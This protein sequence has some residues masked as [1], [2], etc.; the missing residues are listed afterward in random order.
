VSGAGAF[1]EFSVRT[2]DI[3]ESL[4]FYKLLG[5]EELSIGEVWPHK[6][7][8]VSDGV[9]NIGLH[10][11]EFDSPAL[12][13]VQ[14]DLAK[15]ARSM[16]DHGFEFTR[17]QLG[18][19]AFNELHLSDLD[20]N[21]V[22]MLEARTHYGADEDHIDSACGTWFELTMPVKDAVHAAR[23][24]APLAPVVLKMRE[25]PTT[26]MRFDAGGIALGLSESIALHGPSLCFKCH[27][28][29]A[30]E[31][32]CEQHGFASQTFPGFEGAFRAIKA[33]EGTCLYLFDED[34]LGE[35]IEVDESDDLSEFPR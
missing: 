9:L 15:H 27:D 8:V 30:I 3:L 25:E 4:N 16:S 33:P 20:Q 7:T 21:T 11:R 31:A 23:F 2:P 17:M 29:D 34:F 26:H 13:F 14:P 6:Y 1:L 35:A 5:F 18:E 19:D 32:L 12:T 10:D 24:W 22:I 28:R